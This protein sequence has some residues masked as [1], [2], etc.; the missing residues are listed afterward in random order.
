MSAEESDF[1]GFERLAI[2]RR[3]DL[4]WVSLDNPERANALSPALL[5]ELTDLYRRPLLDDGIR[6]LILKANGRHFSAGAD[7]AHLRSLRD[8]GPEENAVDSRRLM[9][10]FEAVLRQETL[11]LALVHGSCVAGGCGLATAHDFV[12]SSQDARYLYSEVRIGFVAA[13]VATYLSLRLRGSDIRELLLYPQFLSA[14]RALE[15]GLVNRVVPREELEQ[16]GEEL[17]AGILANGSSRSIASTKRLLLDL[18]GRSLA[19]GLRH[20]AEVNALAR[21][22]DDCKRGI[23][24]VLDHKRPPTWR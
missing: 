9:D 14:E 1:A 4:L 24:H 2:E 12:V 19:D 22:T 16:A 13:L 10:L 11:T 23:A 20:A 21:E 15:I 17:A 6:A 7:L 3:D 18:P 5:D 8:A